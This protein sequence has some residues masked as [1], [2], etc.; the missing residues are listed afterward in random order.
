[1]LKEMSVPSTATQPDLMKS[2]KG[3]RGGKVIFTLFR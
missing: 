3:E 2:V 1:M